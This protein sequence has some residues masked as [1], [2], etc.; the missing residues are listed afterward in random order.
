MTVYFLTRKEIGRE[1]FLLIL[2]AIKRIVF[3]D[4]ENPRVWYRGEQIK[5]P[6]SILRQLSSVF[7]ILNG[8]CILLIRKVELVNE[9][10]VNIW[11]F[12]SE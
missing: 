3:R 5:S 6:R 8:K 4:V 7:E 9:E 12:P 11:T 10:L 1:N 2:R